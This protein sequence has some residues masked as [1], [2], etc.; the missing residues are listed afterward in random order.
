LYFDITHSTKF[1]TQSTTTSFWFRAK[2]VS[3]QIHNLDGGQRRF[4]T[5]VIKILGR[6]RFGLRDGVRGDDAKQGRHSG[7]QTNFRHAARRLRRYVIKVWRL[8]S[9]DYAEADDGVKTSRLSSFQRAQ[10]NFKRTGHAK[11]LHLVNF[12]SRVGQ[13][14]LCP[15]DQARDKYIVPATGDDRKAEIFSAEAGFSLR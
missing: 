6:A 12:D 11:K 2:T 13:R 14:S 3:I 8:S 10:R 15:F 7:F 4:V 9:N 5:F 1:Q